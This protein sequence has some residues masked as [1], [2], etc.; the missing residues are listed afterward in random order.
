MRYNKPTD[1]NTTRNT[2]WVLTTPC[3]KQSQYNL[4]HLLFL[5]LQVV[6]RPSSSSRLRCCRAALFFGTL[7]APTSG[8]YSSSL[9]PSAI[10]ILR[11]L[12]GRGRCLVRTLLLAEDFDRVVAAEGWAGI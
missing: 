12:R 11:F 6:T 4:R 5:Q 8:T 7:V 1:A 10:S 2:T 3:W 9:P